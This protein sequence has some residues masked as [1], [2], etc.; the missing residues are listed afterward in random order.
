MSQRLAKAL[1]QVKADN[2]SENLLTEI[3]WIIYT[4]HRAK[5]IAKK[6]YNNLMIQ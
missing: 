5:E 1:A 3:R 2:A 4:L 6:V